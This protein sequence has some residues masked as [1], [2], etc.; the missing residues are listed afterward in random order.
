MNYYKKISRISFFGIFMFFFAIVGI[1]YLLLESLADVGSFWSGIAIL[2]FLLILI[3]A[4]LST[5]RH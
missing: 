3:L 1:S 2:S 5:P 4:F